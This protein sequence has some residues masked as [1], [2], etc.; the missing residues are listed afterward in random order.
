VSD[1]ASE[2]PARVAV[3]GGEVQ[4]LLRG[5]VVISSLEQGRDGRLAVLAASDKMSSEFMR[6]RTTNCAC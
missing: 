2:Y 4:R 3:N 6:W 5:P 1:D